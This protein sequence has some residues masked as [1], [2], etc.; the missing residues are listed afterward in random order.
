LFFLLQAYMQRYRPSFTPTAQTSLLWVGAFLVPKLGQEY[1][2][3]SAKLLD[4]LVA[5]DII[6]SVTRAVV[7]WFGA[8]F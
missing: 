1:V 4:D 8:A 6:R 5:I 7:H 3:H 2:L